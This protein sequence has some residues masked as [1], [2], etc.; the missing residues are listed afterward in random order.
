MCIKSAIENSNPMVVF[1]KNIGLDCQ[2]FIG[3]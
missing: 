2:L 1:K 3:Q